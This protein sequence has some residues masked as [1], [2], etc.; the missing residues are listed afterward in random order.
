M[1]VKNKALAIAVLLLVV[2]GSVGG[3]S[4]Q[5]GGDSGPKV[6]KAEDGGE[7]EVLSDSDTGDEDRDEFGRPKESGPNGLLISIAYITMSLAGAVLPFLTL[8]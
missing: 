3:C 7:E 8:F 4:K 5:L 2:V 1:P 6:V